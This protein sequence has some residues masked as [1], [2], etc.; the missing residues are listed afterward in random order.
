MTT[1]ARTFPCMRRAGVPVFGG[2]CRVALRA[3][4]NDTRGVRAPRN[5]KRGVRAPRNKSN[6][7]RGRSRSSLQV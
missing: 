2:D 7:T 1:S 5:D 4:R 6:D 3:P